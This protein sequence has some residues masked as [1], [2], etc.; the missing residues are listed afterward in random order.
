MRSFIDIT[1][2]RLGLVLAVAV[3]AG[4]LAMGGVCGGAT[5][6]KP[7]GCDRVVQ[8]RAG[9]AR[10]HGSAGPVQ[11]LVSSLRPGQVGCLR[12]GTYVE[13]VT[14]TR[15]GIGLRPYPGEHARL[16]GRLYFKR[17]SHDDVVRGLILDGRNPRRLPSPTVNGSRIRFSQVDV[18]NHHTGI[19]FVIGS[20]RYGRASGT[21]IEH[22]R[23]HDCGRLPSH[24]IDHGIYVAAAEGTRIV[25]N[26]IYRNADRGIQ[27]YPDAQH[28]VIERNVIDG[29]GEGVI[30]SGDHGY[31]SSWNLVAYNV[32]TNAQIRADVESWYPAGN[33]RGA[34]N[35][36]R[37][38]CLFGGHRTIFARFGGFSATLNAIADPHFANR[39]A[40]NF[41]IPAGNPCARVLAG[42]APDLRAVQAA[43]RVP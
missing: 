3:L 34:G 6:P 32:I 40:G 37:A 17:G 25:G 27:L 15:S 19:C 26:L 13:D 7:R 31:A 33:P 41:R 1:T 29:N 42:H 35:V 4:V 12:S 28:T 24:N 39:A 5:S 16:L 22:S 23:I 20:G 38:N 21:V 8:P 36:V 9:A 14:V 43:P 10:S 30:F 2:S 18:T 11:R